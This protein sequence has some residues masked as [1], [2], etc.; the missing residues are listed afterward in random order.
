MGKNQIVTTQPVT[1][2]NKKKYDKL[3]TQNVTKL[4]NPKC[5]ENQKIILWQS[6]NY[7]IEDKTWQFNLWLYSKT[8]IVKK[9]KD[10]K[11]DKT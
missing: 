3:E 8:Q 9:F 5:D 4:K 7:Q 6:I 2:K 1:K 11:C 10:L